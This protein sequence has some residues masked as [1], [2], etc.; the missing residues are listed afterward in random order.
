[1]WTYCKR[2]CEGAGEEERGRGR[3]DGGGGGKKSIKQSVK[4]SLLPEA[5]PSG[6]LSVQK[7]PL[8]TQ[9]ETEVGNNSGRGQEAAEPG[10]RGTSSLLSPRSMGSTP[11][12]LFSP[13]TP[14]LRFAL[15]ASKRGTLSE[16]G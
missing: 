15:A 7:V 4:A 8:S 5:Q 13:P 10:K 12:G 2:T 9:Q 6:R 3:A 1:M 16:V 14:G 11:R